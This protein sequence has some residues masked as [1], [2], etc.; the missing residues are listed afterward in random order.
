MGLRPEPI[1]QTS[2]T[3]TLTKHGPPRQPARFSHQTTQR[4][5]RKTLVG[6]DTPTTTP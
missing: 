5:R 4:W 3:S 1:R 6:E 2:D